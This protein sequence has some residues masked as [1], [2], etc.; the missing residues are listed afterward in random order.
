MKLTRRLIALL[1]V[2]SA[3]L[4]AQSTPSPALLAL[5]K[6][7][8]TLAIVDPATLKVVVRIPAGPD[9][10]ELI[11]S[12]DGRFAYVSN[13]G[14]GTYNTITVIDLVAQK[15]IS[16]VDVGPLRGPHGL[17]F[18]S[19][20]LWF[21][22]EVAK[23][24]GRYDPVTNKVDMVLGTG[25]NRIHMIAVSADSK[26][27]V[28]TNVTSATVTITDR[29][30]TPSATGTA[31]TDWEHTIVPVGRDA[32]GFDISSV[33]RELWVANALDGTISIIDAASRKVTQT[34]NANVEGANRLKFTPDGKLVF[35]ASLRS[36]DVAVFD[37]ATRKEVRRIKVGTG[38]AGMQ[39][40]PDGK[41]LFVACS[42]DNYVTVID[43]TT[44]A[45]VAKIDVG[46]L[47]DGLGWAVRK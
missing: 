28:T 45:V 35:V 37:A 39:M 16:T 1:T 46:K 30:A 25:Q 4:N 19:G 18:V 21:T 6:S 2:L 31:E 29:A 14:R 17:D 24:I 26:R 33:N 38:A 7:E 15:V 23:S 3:G 27:I 32:E 20:K 11:T 12:T 34:L 5:S 47:P 13:Y 9:P 43:L 10:H 40:Q 36:T 22:T 42:P 44:M 8:M 41:R